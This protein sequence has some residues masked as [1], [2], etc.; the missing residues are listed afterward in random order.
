MKRVVTLL[1]AAL[2]LLALVSLVSAQDT[3][4]LTFNGFT[5]SYPADLATSV[6]TSARPGDPPDVMYP[7]GPVPPHTLIELL[8]YA[9]FPGADSFPLARIAVFRTAD[10]APYPAFVEQFQALQD[11]LTTRPD[12]TSYTVQAAEMGDNPQLPFLPV[13]PATQ[14][15]RAQP[16][17]YDVG[18]YSGIRY[19][20]IYSQDVSPF[21]NTTVSYTFQGISA[22]G[23]TYIAV[24]MR[25]L[26][27]ALPAG[28]PADFNY[29][30][31]AADY[32]GYLSET[33]A[34]LNSA[35]ATSFNPPLPILDAMVTSFGITEGA[36]VTTPPV[37]PTATP[38]VGV[39]GGTWLLFSY[40]D[41]AAP[42]FPLE[43]TTIDLIFAPDGISG[44]GGCNQYFGGFTFSD[45]TISFTAVGATQRACDEAI[46][47]QEAAYFAALSTASLFSTEDDSLS[48]A[49][50]GGVLIFNRAE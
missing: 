29:D 34:L 21:L 12:L 37:V 42:I 1:F 28:I 11:L 25:L 13:P 14:V 10:F 18:V 23:S 41:T 48:I 17:Y 4:T 47:Q 2:A 36:A 19:L 49:Y 35:A 7:G 31:F 24:D 38:S 3:N 26:S 6:R 30:A 33:S 20:T 8:G 45:N 15:I 46:M 32:A 50:E 16:L 40:G 22:D 43:G 39:L 44:S 9:P 27:D 5:F